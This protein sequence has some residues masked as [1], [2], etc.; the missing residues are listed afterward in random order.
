VPVLTVVAG[1]NGSGK[2]TMTKAVDFEGRERL[3]DPDAVA[4]RLN[5]GTPHSVGLTAGREILRRIQ[6]YL[7][8]RL[9]FAIETTL[10][11]KRT[12]AMM[13]KA[14]ASGFTVQ[15]VCKVATMFPTGMFVVDTP[16]VWRIC[17]T[18]SERQIERLST[19]IPG[20]RT[21]RCWRPK[22]LDYME[23]GET[24]TMGS[25]AARRIAGLNPLFTAPARGRPR[26]ALCT[27]CAR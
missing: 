20:M 26:A 3:L 11:S 7:D 23:R 19:T 12:L 10:A 5:P 13:Q 2:S 14:K 24:T 18:R 17:P 9:S 15:L 21:E 4:W 27:T 22:R 16:A 8:R 6:D 1:P 25:S